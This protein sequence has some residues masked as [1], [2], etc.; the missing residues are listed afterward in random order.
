MEWFQEIWRYGDERQRLIQLKHQLTDLSEQMRRTTSG[1]KTRSEAFQ[2]AI[3]EYGYEADLILSEI[4][5][6]ETGQALRRA[7]KWRVPIPKRPFSEYG[8]DTDF[9]EWSSAHGR[10]YLTDFGLR[11]VRKMVHDEREMMSR[12]V[13]S[14]AALGISVISLIVA[15]LKP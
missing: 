11:E 2:S 5:E 14:W 12:P 4:A 13:L 7:E 3:S 15:A 9:W 1:L 8:Q 10:Y 6:I